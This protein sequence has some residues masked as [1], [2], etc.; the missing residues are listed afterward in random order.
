M[1]HS[2]VL[3]T[4][5]ALLKWIAPPFGYHLVPFSFTPHQKHC[6][7]VMKGTE[8]G[9]DGGSKGD[10]WIMSDHKRVGLRRAFSPS[11]LSAAPGSNIHLA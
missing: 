8:G 4:E 10:G 7:S 9:R 3:H 11:G 1:Q 6:P 2:P 5:Q